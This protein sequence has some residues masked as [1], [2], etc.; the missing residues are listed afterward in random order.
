MYPARIL[1]TKAGRIRSL[2]GLNVPFS[3]VKEHLPMYLKIVFALLTKFQYSHGGVDHLL[4]GLSRIGLK[5]GLTQNDLHTFINWQ[6]HSRHKDKSFYFT[7]I[8]FKRNKDMMKVIRYIM[9]RTMKTMTM[10]MI[11]M[12]MMNKQDKSS[13]T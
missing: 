10:M 12:M 2:G 1:G 3:L 11:T 13:H 6:C 7:Y 5:D 8:F 9:M 4:L